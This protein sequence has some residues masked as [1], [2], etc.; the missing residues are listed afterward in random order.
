MQIL[1][2]LNKG[3]HLNTIERFYTYAEYLNNQLNDENA[4]FSNKIFEVILKPHQP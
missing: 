4:V 1:L 2:R 3:L